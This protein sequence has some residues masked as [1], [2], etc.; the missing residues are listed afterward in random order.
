MKMWKKF[1]KSPI[2]MYKVPFSN[3]WHV[4]ALMWNTPVNYKEGLEVVSDLHGV[5]TL[6]A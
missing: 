5:F 6:L 1:T 4:K 2:K 3:H